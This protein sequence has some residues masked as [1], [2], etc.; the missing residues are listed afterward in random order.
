[1]RKSPKLFSS[2]GFLLCFLIFSFGAAQSVAQDQ[3]FESYLKQNFGAIPGAAVAV[4]YQG[5]IVFEGGSGYAD[6]EKRTLIDPNTRF[7][8]ASVTK[9][10]TAMAVMMQKESG[11]F[12]YDSPVTQFFPEFSGFGDGVTIRNLLQHT[13]GFP[14]YSELCRGPGPARNDDIVKLMVNKGRLDFRPGARFVYSNT[15]Y[16]LLAVLVERTSGLSYPDFVEQKIFSPLG[17]KET[18]VNRWGIPPKTNLARSYNN[19]PTPAESPDVVNCN[20]IYGDGSVFST[21]HDMALWNLYLEKYTVVG[22]AASM[23]EAYQPAKT[24]DGGTSSYGFGWGL[25]SRSGMKQYS[26][27][28][29]W[30]GYRTLNARFPEKQFAVVVLTNAPRGDLQALVNKAIEMYMR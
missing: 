19:P 11:K 12:Q 14:D 30:A 17:M 18:F 27:T 15:G 21:A 29:A 7:E 26:H 28:G 2:F 16:D 24:A 9:Q 10:I 8:L 22:T 1:M 13:G 23:E 5:K 20:T 3:T 6:A 25:G 4:T